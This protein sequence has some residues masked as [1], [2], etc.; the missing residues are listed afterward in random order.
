MIFIIK[1]AWEYISLKTSDGVMVY[2]LRKSNAEING[3][4]GKTADLRKLLI[5]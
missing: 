1:E 3:L 5:V 2:N 4:K